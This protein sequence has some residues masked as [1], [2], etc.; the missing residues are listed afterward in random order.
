VLVEDS[1]YKRVVE[2]RAS[3]REVIFYLTTRARAL[4]AVP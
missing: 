1:L 3:P 4:E 2:G